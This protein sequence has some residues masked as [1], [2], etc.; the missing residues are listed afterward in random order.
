[1]GEDLYGDN[2]L[3]Q[4]GVKGMKWGSRKNRKKE[5][6]RSRIGGEKKK[7]TT[8]NNKILTKS[9]AGGAKEKARVAAF[10]KAAEPK[11]LR[12][13]KVIATGGT[14][15]SKSAL[16]QQHQAFMKKKGADNVSG[17]MGEIGAQAMGGLVVGIALSAVNDY[18]FG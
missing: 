12:A 1:M 16:V 13:L 4:S 14:S 10:K 7:A 5:L 2:Y 3:V 8:R 11:I 15:K 18:L 9:K 6:T 17:Y